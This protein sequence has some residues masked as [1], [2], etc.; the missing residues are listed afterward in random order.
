MPALN[1]KHARTSHHCSDMS[2]TTA[3]ELGHGHTI[4]RTLKDYR[5]TASKEQ[6]LLRG[7]PGALDYRTGEGQGKSGGDKGTVMPLGWGA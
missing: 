1:R 3:S 7:G 6:L 5:Q 2:S 4:Y